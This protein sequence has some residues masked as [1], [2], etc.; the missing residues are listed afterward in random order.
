MA[1][2]VEQGDLAPCDHHLGPD[3]IRAHGTALRLPARDSDKRVH[4]GHVFC[5]RCATGCD[6]RP[7]VRC[8]RL[9]GRNEPPEDRDNGSFVIL[10]YI[11]T[12]RGF[13]RRPSSAECL[14][15][16]C[17]LSNRDYPCRRTGP[18]AERITSSSRASAMLAFTSSPAPPLPSHSQYC[19]GVLAGTGWPPGRLPVEAASLVK[20]RNG[21]KNPVHSH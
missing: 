11:F 5:R 6:S 7:L 15:R 21:F 1:R 19:L 3:F 18:A 14:Q 9:R 16:L 10:P 20:R 4:V 12:G 13:C 2:A 17:A 8:D